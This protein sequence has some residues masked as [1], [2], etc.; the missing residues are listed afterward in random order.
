MS[1]VGWRYREA[2]AETLRNIAAVKKNGAWAAR[3]WR[4][5]GGCVRQLLGRLFDAIQL[6]QHQLQQQRHHLVGGRPRALRPL[7]AGCFLAPKHDQ[8]RG[9]P[10]QDSRIQPWHIMK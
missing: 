8:Q 3:G 6:P 9:R 4:L 10:S 5:V 7:L 1:V 2:S